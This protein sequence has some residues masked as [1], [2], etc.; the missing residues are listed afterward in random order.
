MKPKREFTSATDASESSGPFGYPSVDSNGAGPYPQLDPLP[1]YPAM[2]TVDPTA[3]VDKNEENKSANQ[4]FGYPSFDSTNINSMPP[5]RNSDYSDPNSLAYPSIDNNPVHQPTSSSKSSKKKPV[6][7][8]PLSYPTFDDNG[9]IESNEYEPTASTQLPYRSSTMSKPEQEVSIEESCLFC[10]LLTL[11]VNYEFDESNCLTPSHVRKALDQVTGNN[12]IQGFNEGSMACAQETFEEILRY[13]HREYIKPN[14]YEK[15]CHDPKKL[16]KQEEKY[17]DTGCSLNCTAHK[18]FGLEIGEFLSCDNC[19]YVAE[20]QCS[21]LD[22]LINLYAEELLKLK[23]SQ[24]DAIDTLVQKMYK[25]ESHERKTEPKTCAS[26][27]K[28]TLE[29]KTMNLFS[30]PNVFTFAIHWVDPDEAKRDEI[31]RIFQLITPLIDAQ[32]FMHTQTKDERKT[33]FIL[34]GF[35]SYY[36]KHY[37]AYFYSEQHDY[38]MHLDDSKITEVGNFQDVVNMCI[39]GKELPILLFYESQSFLEDVLPDP[40][41]KEKAYYR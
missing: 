32:Q 1:S 4:E 27:K 21:H 20:V 9:N 31:E 6:S 38:W 36:G 3:P 35:I 37:M 29:P 16:K 17:E 2:G 39:K 8:G 10:N 14:Y 24:S 18:V 7:T 23:C 28:A 41:K 26:C 22:F 19:E 15:Y 13:L 30:N 34:R 5:E 25:H 12:E 11:F 40:S 33:T